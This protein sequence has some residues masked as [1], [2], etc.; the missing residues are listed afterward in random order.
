MWKLVIEDDEG[1]RTVVPLTREGYTIGRQDG[2]TIRL[3]ERNVS[4]QHARLKRVN[5]GGANTYVLEDCQSYNGV[6]VNGARVA[7]E[8]PLQH[9]DLVQIGDYRILL[10]DDTIADEVVTSDVSPD[11]KATHPTSATAS[12]RGSLLLE[13]PN[14]LV[15]LAGPT[16]GIEFPLEG[17]LLTV[18]RAEEADI[19]INH[20]SVSRMHCEIHALREGRFEIVDKG[21]SNGVRVN[22][23]DL[24]RGI[25]EAGDVI[26]LGDVRFK[27]VGAGQVFLPG[28]TD[29][30]RLEAIADRIPTAEP[31]RTGSVF[32]WLLVGG[33]VAAIG[34][35]VWT[36]RQRTKPRG[37]PN[38]IA[39]TTTAP[40]PLAA[41][42]ADAKRSCAAG[43]C[44]DAHQRVIEAIPE[45][46]PLRESDDFR[47][48]EVTWA[49]QMLA[50]ADAETDVD[51]K[52]ALLSSVAEAPTVDGT[53]RRL[54][55]TRLESLA[56]GPAASASASAEPTTAP[57]TTKHASHQPTAATSP[58][59]KPKPHTTATAPTRKPSTSGSEFDRASKLA[60]D[61]NLA[62]A[63]QI[64]DPKVF[65]GKG[66]PDEK[67]LLKSICKQQ[68]NQVCLDKLKSM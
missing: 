22:G 21:S 15:M 51:I 23:A 42:L 33:L 46:S 52:R 26:E 27:F 61:G 41:V 55:A 38:T 53:R 5:G 57:T 48:I 3:T 64:L 58:T 13:R 66:T 18:G 37:I 14:R 8:Q 68:G 54:A 20:N 1:Q 65:G 62:G 28:V 47:L 17:E 34:F 6:Y 30:Q 39:S 4:R 12:T 50:R 11:L 19:S 40:D 49:D 16:P 7:D 2:S 10:Q 45:G 63:R 43:H 59:R 36:L 29:S 44:D 32:P 25:I 60:L 67:R 56:G 35:G 9:G 24:R 31:G